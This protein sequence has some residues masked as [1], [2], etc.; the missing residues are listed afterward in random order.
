[1]KRCVGYRILTDTVK[2]STLGKQA[3]REFGHSQT[4]GV[5]A[6]DVVLVDAEL[7]LWG[8]FMGVS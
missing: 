7:H 4:F 5:D 1:M 8:D 6:F 3:F 2:R